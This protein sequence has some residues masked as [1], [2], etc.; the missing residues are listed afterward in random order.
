MTKPILREAIAARQPLSRPGTC[1]WRAHS[2]G[3]LEAEAC[4]TGAGVGHRRGARPVSG[5]SGS[6]RQ[7]RPARS[8][9]GRTCLL[10]GPQPERRRATRVPPR[11]VPVGLVEGRRPGLRVPDGFERMAVERALPRS[12]G[13]DCRMERARVVGLPLSGRRGPR[14]NGDA[15]PGPPTRHERRFDAE[16]D[17]AQAQEPPD[18]DLHDP[19]RLRRLRAVADG[20]N[21]RATSSRERDA[22]PTPACDDAWEQ[23]LATVVHPVHPRSVSAGQSPRFRGRLRA[24]HRVVRIRHSQRPFRESVFPCVFMDRDRDRGTACKEPAWP[25]P[26][27]LPRAAQVDRR[28]PVLERERQDDVDAG[29]R[30]GR[31]PA[32]SEEHAGVAHVDRDAWVPFRRAML[33]VPEW[34]RDGEPPCQARR[35]GPGHVASLSFFRGR[36]P[37]RPRG[38]HGRAAVASLGPRRTGRGEDRRRPSSG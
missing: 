28:C 26:N 18:V 11:R 25:R 2:P 14:R 36:S 8:R 3:F 17:Q 12:G 35:I 13:A 32:D 27:D 31:S 15:G 4:R 23:A 38:S 20:E 6:H 33:A 34:R 7:R 30:L 9:L 5:R 10:T 37:A 29:A 16:H 22:A 19:L 24:L 21:P 1:G